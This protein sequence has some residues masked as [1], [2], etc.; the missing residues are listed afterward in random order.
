MTELKVVPSE[1]NYFDLKR[2]DEINGEEFFEVP[3]ASIGATYEFVSDLLMPFST[4]PY[5]NCY[6]K[7][8]KRKERV[9]FL[10]NDDDSCMEVVTGTVFK[11]ERD[12]LYSEKTG[13][14]IINDHPFT[15]IS[16][17]RFVER[18]QP[19]RGY[20]KNMTRLFNHFEQLQKRDSYLRSNMFTMALKHEMPLEYETVEKIKDTVV[21]TRTKG[22]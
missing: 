18:L 7:L 1:Y 17:K 10:K 9:L 21:K 5:N 22:N 3:I 20:A 19:N 2:Y 11:K 13:L 4:N 16:P 12:G 8:Y 6:G 14:Y 15:T